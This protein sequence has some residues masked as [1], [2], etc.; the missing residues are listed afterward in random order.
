MSKKLVMKNQQFQKST[1]TT[2]FANLILVSAVVSMLKIYL[3]HKFQWPQESLNCGQVIWP[4]GFGNYFVCK[5]FVVQTLLWSLEFVIQINIEHDIIV[6]WNLPQSWNIST[7]K[8]FFYFIYNALFVLEI[9][10][11]LYFYLLLFF[12][13][14]AIALEVDPR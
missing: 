8:F 2:S 7:M 5:R 13:L 12:S 11:F 4:S 14:S 9:F 6:V 3:N 10:K 1:K